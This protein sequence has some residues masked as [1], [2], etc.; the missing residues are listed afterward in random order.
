MPTEAQIESFTK[1]V[2]EG[3]FVEAIEQ[4]YHTDASMQENEAPPRYGKEALIAHERSF[5]ESLQSISCRLLGPVMINGDH[6]T[7]R[8]RFDFQPLDGP[9]RS[10]E[11]IAYQ[12]WQGD[13]V[14]REKFFYDPKQIGR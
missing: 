2:E 3:H 10:M 12:F 6:V 9:V 1:L 14:L 4:Y 5:L 11:E 8:W 7:I 13:R